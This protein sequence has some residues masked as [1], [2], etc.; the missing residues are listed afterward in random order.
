MSHDCVN[1]GAESSTTETT[2]TES[3]QTSAIPTTYT[4]MPSQ[5]PSQQHFTSTNFSPITVAIAPTVQP[6]PTSHEDTDKANPTQIVTVVSTT[7]LESKYIFGIVVTG[8]VVIVL[9]LAL[10]ISITGLSV[11][12]KSRRNHNHD[13][14]VDTF[15]Q[16]SDNEAYKS[17]T[18]LITESN[19]NTAENLTQDLHT[20]C[21]T[22]RRNMAYQTSYATSGHGHSMHPST[23]LKLQAPDSHP[24]TIAT[25]TNQAYNITN[26]NSSTHSDIVHVQVPQVNMAQNSHLNSTETGRN[27]IHQASIETLGRNDIMHPALI[28]DLNWVQV[29]MAMTS[30]D[31]TSNDASSDSLVVTRPTDDSHDLNHTFQMKVNEAYHAKV[32]TMTQGVSAESGD[33]HHPRGSATV[34]SSDNEANGAVWNASRSTQTSQKVKPYEITKLPGIEAVEND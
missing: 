33:R 22:T 23:D 2:E 11:F 15:I 16:T 3:E 32:G 8:I 5:T 9:F 18:T 12:V 20:N 26:K 7:F 24:N 21:I 4:T 6:Q 14:F 31:H 19:H 27:V 17:R 13:E 25:R 34:A 29:S 1:A 28:D 30:S 10:A